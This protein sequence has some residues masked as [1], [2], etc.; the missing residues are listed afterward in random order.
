MP[1][2]NN[3]RESHED[4][5]LGERVLE[6]V[7]RAVNQLA[8]VVER[9]DAHARRKARRKLRDAL[10]DAL[11]DGLRVLAVPHDD[12]AADDFMPV[13]VE[14]A[15][16]EVAADLHR[17]DVLEVNRRALARLHGD[18]FEVFRAFDKADAAQH[19]LRAIFLHDFAADVEV[20][21][22]HGGHHLHHAH[23]RRAHLRRGK[24]DLI[25][26]H[27]AADACDLGHSIHARKCVADIPILQRTQPREVVAFLRWVNVEIVLIHPAE[28]RRIRAKLRLHALG[29]GALQI[30]QPLQHAG[31]GEIRVNAVFE[32]Y[33][34]ER[35]SEH[36]SGAHVF[37]T[38][39]TLEAGGE[40]IRHL[41]FHLLRTATHPVCID[42]HLVFREVGNGVHGRRGNGA[43][44]ERH[45][46]QHAARDEEAVSQTPL[47]DAFNH[48]ASGFDFRAAVEHLDAHVRIAD[49]PARE[50]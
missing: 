28:A 35:E 41:V 39:Q 42:E 22:L 33:R 4:D 26:L 32:N 6:R 45:E 20:R 16:P 25:L 18:E 24:L 48:G 8:A 15:A 2:E 21:V 11:D 23:A 17:R 1:E 14:R 34:D 29:H 19:K 43:D 40:R 50:L 49:A 5:F 38:R 27:K 3:V 31:A 47:D 10:L 36:R 30:I 12:C 44:A 9:L 46:Q 7:N 37:H 13:H